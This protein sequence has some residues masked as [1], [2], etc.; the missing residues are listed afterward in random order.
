MP[1]IPAFTKAKGAA[2]IFA[3]ALLIASCGNNTQEAA[4]KPTSTPSAASSDATIPSATAEPTAEENTS[5]ARE[6]SAAS[7]DGESGTATPSTDASSGTPEPTSKVTAPKS[8]STGPR[9]I[10][11]HR[12]K[13]LARILGRAEKDVDFPFSKAD[14]EKVVAA[15]LPGD[16]SGDT[17]VTCEDATM[18]A[19]GLDPIQCKY[20]DG[21]GKERTAS[22]HGTSSAIDGTGLLV[23]PLGDGLSTDPLAKAYRAKGAEIFAYGAGSMYGVTAPVTKEDLAAQVKASLEYWGRTDIA[24]VTCNSEVSLEDGGKNVTGCTITL[25][26]GTEVPA[27]TVLAFLP[28]TGDNGTVTV[29][30]FP[31][32]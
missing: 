8:A 1:T 20:T 24:S 12:T 6:S 17:P 26:D 7:Q 11:H 21:D 31:N 3:T 25:K 29:A 14:L 5:G 30:D 27:V 4:P 15:S 13:D 9:M 18:R 28:N 32:T 2:A 10:A 22:V 16:G 19:I 23:F